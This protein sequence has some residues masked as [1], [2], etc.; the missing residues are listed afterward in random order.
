MT[1]LR[2]PM[3]RISRVP[4]ALEGVG[5]EYTTPAMIKIARVRETIGGVDDEHTSPHYRSNLTGS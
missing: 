4:E 5:D 2:P 1:T 3:I